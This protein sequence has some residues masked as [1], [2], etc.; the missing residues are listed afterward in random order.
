MVTESKHN[1]N[2][3]P[4]RGDVV[5]MDFDPQTG[6]EIWDR[7]PALVIS[8]WDF[9]HKKNLAIV[10]PITSTKR[11]GPFEVEI[12]DGLKVHGVIRTDQVKSLDW[13]ARNAKLR[14]E[15]L[16]DI[17]TTVCQIV[18]TIIWGE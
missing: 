5:N 12:P 15:M 2:Y 1:C 17:V 3:I 16:D 14:C 11:G 7:R 9:N 18:E 4:V 13:Q 10:C 8:S 6:K